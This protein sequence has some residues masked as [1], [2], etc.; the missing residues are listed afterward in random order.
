MHL[1][2]PIIQFLKQDVISKIKMID[3]MNLTKTKNKANEK[4]ILP[5]ISV[6]ATDGSSTARLVGKGALCNHGDT[7]RLQRCEV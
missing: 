3:K 7:H 2:Y 6:T 1:Y 4:K 5:S